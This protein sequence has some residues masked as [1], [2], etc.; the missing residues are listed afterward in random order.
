M[1][2]VKKTCY[3]LEPLLKS[4]GTFAE[5]HITESLVKSRGTF[6]EGTSITPINRIEVPLSH[7]TNEISK[8]MLDNGYVNHNFTQK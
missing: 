6:A 1:G 7:K 4:R 2:S 3:S 8:Q 5:E